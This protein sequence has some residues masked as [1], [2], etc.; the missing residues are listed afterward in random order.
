MILSLL[1]GSD[2]IAQNRLDALIKDVG[3]DPNILWYPS[4]GNDYRDVLETSSPR[5]DQHGI[6]LLPKLYIHTD[7]SRSHV[8]LD[9][10]IHDD[11]RTI[12]KLTEKYKLKFKNRVDYYVNPEH[13]TMSSEVYFEP[14]VYLLDI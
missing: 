6:K 11:G 2:R 12:V 13:I 4:A 5:V 1:C 3:N 9:G 10:I 14:L 8:K 7:Y